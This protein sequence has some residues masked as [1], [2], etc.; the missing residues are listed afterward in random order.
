M[1]KKELIDFQLMIHSSQNK[2]VCRMGLALLC[3]HF[4]G[5]IKLAANYYYIAVSTDAAVPYGMAEFEIP[6]A[7]W[8]VFENT[9][10]FKENV[11][12]LF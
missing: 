12:S 11:Q 3:A 4:E 1:E 6:A 8:V 2:T 5:F 7:T 10:R 9:G